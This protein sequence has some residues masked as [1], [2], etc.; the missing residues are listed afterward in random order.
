MLFC[1]CFSSVLF[2]TVVGVCVIPVYSR[3]S[4]C[5]V[6]ANLPEVNGFLLEI[7]VAAFIDCIRQ[8]GLEV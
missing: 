6:I 3:S 7:T 5:V 2:T 1:S 8:G 4:D